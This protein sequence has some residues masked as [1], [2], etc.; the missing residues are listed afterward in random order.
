M[1]PL[2]VSLGSVTI[3]NIQSVCNDPLRP[4][5]YLHDNRNATPIRNF[6]YLATVKALF[7]FVLELSS[8]GVNITTEKILLRGVGREAASAIEVARIS[9]RSN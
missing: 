2:R 6:S 4:R 8:K 5:Q 9:P 1:V 7:F 3:V